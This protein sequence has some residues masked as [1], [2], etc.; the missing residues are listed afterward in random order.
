MFYITLIFKKMENPTKDKV[1][2]KRRYKYTKYE[3][4]LFLTKW[5]YKGLLETMVRLDFHPR[6]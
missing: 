3:R 1:L 2:N 4:T 5:F 6:M